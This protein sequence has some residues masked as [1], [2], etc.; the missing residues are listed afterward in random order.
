[1]KK[2][3][4][5]INGSQTF[6]F[7]SKCKFCKSGPKYVY[8]LLNRVITENNLY[9]IRDY[10]IMSSTSIRSDDFYTGYSIRNRSFKPSFMF[11]STMLSLQKLPVPNI[12]YEQNLDRIGTV[13]ECGCG[14]TSWGSIRSNRKHIKYR[15]C[16]ININAK[17]IMS[18]YKILL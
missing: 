9:K 7:K 13:I 2:I 16:P 17:D 12:K 5:K 10:S 6:Y 8:Y 3:A 18:L 11:D 1:M 4:T 15:K 14:K